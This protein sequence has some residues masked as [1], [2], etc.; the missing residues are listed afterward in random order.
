MQDHRNGGVPTRPPDRDS[1]DYRAQRMVL[2]ELVVG[3]PDDW[4]RL[5][6]LIDRLGLPGHSI[7]P[8]VA[9]LELVGLAER[10]DD[11][12]RASVAASYFEYL[13]RVRP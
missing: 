9:A 10:K 8:A 7:E 4:D 1:L 5:D 3:P 6:E 11:A 12:V 2:L 13:W